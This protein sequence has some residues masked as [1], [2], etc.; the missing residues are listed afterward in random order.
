M[1]VYEEISGSPLRAPLL[2]S[3]RPIS[4]VTAD[5][6]PVHEAEWDRWY[7]ESH[8]PGVLRA[9]GYVGGSAVPAAGPPGGQ[10]P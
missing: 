10:G 7:T 1:N 9:P 5:V 3:D 6:D 8:L 4:I 2:L